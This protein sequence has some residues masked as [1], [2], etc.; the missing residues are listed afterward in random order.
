MLFVRGDRTV[1]ASSQSATTVIL[2]T[3]GKIYS[4]SNPPDSVVVPS[5]KFQSVGNPYAAAI[6]FNSLI[7]TSTNIDS[8]YYYVWDPLFQSTN[9]FGGYQ[10]IS[11]T[12][13]PVPGG[14]AN[15]AIF[16]QYTQ[17]QSGQ[18]IFVRSIGSTNGK[19]K[20]DETNKVS[21]NRNVFRN[22][23]LIPFSSLR[24]FL[25]ANDEKLVDGNLL[26][27]DN[28]FSNA[29]DINDAP[30]LNNFA[31][32]FGIRSS[33]KILAIETR[34][35]LNN[36][37]TLFYNLTN[38]RVQS[39]KFKFVPENMQ[40]LPLA[41]YLIDKFTGQQ[42]QLNLA[43][44]NLISFSIINNPASYASDRFYIVFKHLRP[45][46][47]TFT[48]IRAAKQNKNI[49]VD[50]A[51]SNELNTLKYNVQK[52]SNGIQFS[53]IGSQLATGNNG[54]NQ[55]YNF[56]DHAPFNG[57]NYY[58]IQSIGISPDDHKYSNIVKVLI[59][60]QKSKIIVSPNPIT[61]NT[62]GLTFFNK[63]KGIYT[64]RLYNSFGQLVLSKIITHPVS[65]NADYNI[66]P[67]S[68]LAA[69]I[70]T[71]KITNSDGSKMAE[72]VIIE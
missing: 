45:L 30:K 52:S 21:G 16:E 53:K 49:V 20:F 34:A 4:P 55:Q 36:I 23:G 41:A 43:D 51:V 56:I 19:V 11:R 70:Y 13:G 46:P 42:T 50:W 31:E 38:L 71:I 7:S 24:S 72:K 29:I 27:I 66:K 48:D 9:G 18:A 44:T 39:Y 59:E 6:D 61:G 54:S 32:N 37:D 14:T 35:S 33:N 8:N 63:A 10:V 22:T 2:R 47:V 64:T 65:G 60:N 5:G 1:V 40:N 12:S 58:R 25:L 68:V 17:I 26:N 15:Y 57:Y 3:T 28:Q 69:G 62:I 67:E